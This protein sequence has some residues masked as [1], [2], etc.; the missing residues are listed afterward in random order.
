MRSL[1]EAI[2]SSRGVRARFALLMVLMMALG[3]ALLLP[4]M[5]LMPSRNPERL[6]RYF[7]AHATGTPEGV[8]P[9][10]HPL[11]AEALSGFLTGK[12]PGA[13]A[14][15]CVGDLCIQA[16]T[17]QELAHLQDV[18][19]LYQLARSMAFLG[20]ILLLV[21][22][23]LAVKIAQCNLR[24]TVFL[25]ARWLWFA[26]LL[27]LILLALLALLVFVDFTGAF[28]V[29]HEVLFS[30]RLWQLNPQT[31]LLVQLMPE[32]FFLAY[33][34]DTLRRIALGLLALLAV[35]WVVYKA[36]KAGKATF[37]TD[38]PENS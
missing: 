3:F 22:I 20:I 32:S 15:I 36:L 7:D 24:A 34:Q 30:N 13:Q 31:D 14:W 4:E 33:F 6:A 1:S 35:S 26:I 27:T 21:P 11:L 28:T 25:Y 9:D 23:A 12:T 2:R 18:R 38:A 5:A 17:L 16:F 37:E 8:S 10:Q 29:L 19:E